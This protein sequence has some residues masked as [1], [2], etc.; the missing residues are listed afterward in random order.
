MY[1]VLATSWTL[2]SGPTNYISLAT[3]AFFGVGMYSVAI[4]VGILP[5]WVLVVIAGVIGAVLAAVVG[6]ATLRISGVYFVIFTFGMTDDPPAMVGADDH[7]LTA[8]LYVLIGMK[9]SRCIGCCWPG[10]DHLPDWMVDRPSDWICVANHRQRWS[11]LRRQH[12]PRSGL[13]VISSIRLVD[14]TL[15]R[16]IWLCRTNPGVHTI[17]R[18]HGAARRA[19]PL[20]GPWWVISPCYGKSSM[21]RSTSDSFVGALLV[22]VYFSAA[23]SG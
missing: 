16:P 1:T 15:W 2:F 19:A 14:A 8:R 12:R 4:G 3:A 7:G 22:I 13:F 20:W 17:S 21:Q 23:W 10:R 9:D 5:Y 11:W 18:G 6:L